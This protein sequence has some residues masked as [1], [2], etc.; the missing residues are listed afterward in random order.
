MRALQADRD[1]SPAISG[2]VSLDLKE[3]RIAAAKQ[4]IAESH[5]AHQRDP[6]YLLL[7][8]RVYVA[9][10]DTVHAESMF[11]QASRDSIAAMNRGVG[12]RRF[13]FERSSI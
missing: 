9:D 6:E 2:I 4:W 8:G 13:S 10:R 5:T 11:R 7:A 12:V 1:F 3:K